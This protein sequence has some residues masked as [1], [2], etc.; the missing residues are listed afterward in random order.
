MSKDKKHHMAAFNGK[1]EIVPGLRIAEPALNQILGINP[2][3]KQ[4]VLRS[5][6]PYKDGNKQYGA[7][8]VTKYPTNYI[9]EDGHVHYGVIPKDGETI[10]LRKGCG[11]PTSPSRFVSICD[12]GHLSPFDY[13]FWAHTKDDDYDKPCRKLGSN[14]RIKLVEGENSAYTLADWVVIC[15][16]CG[17]KNSMEKVPWVEQSN[18]RFA[19]ICHGHRPWLAS[20]GNAKENCDLR[21]VHRQVGNVSVSYS[22]GSSVLLIPPDVSFSLANNDNIQRLLRK[23]QDEGQSFDEF[24]TAFHGL[25]EFLGDPVDLSGTYFDDDDD[26]DAD[27]NWNKFLR[28]LWD[29]KNK[30]MDEDFLTLKNLRGRERGMESLI[31]T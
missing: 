24:S 7:I 26:P 23:A 6:P 20:G 3:G 17:A 18:K 8:N 19:P 13:Q 15:E 22:Q 12:N 11:K 5:V 25:R 21:M 14:A 10:C 31:P 27:P 28:V 29:Y 2:E 4:R 9:C 16:E 30:H 1:N